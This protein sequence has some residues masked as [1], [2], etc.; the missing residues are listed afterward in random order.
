MLQRQVSK[1]SRRLLDEGSSQH[2]WVSSIVS[3]MDCDS[4]PSQCG[5]RGEC[6]LECT[7]VASKSGLEDANVLNMFRV[8]FVSVCL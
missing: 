5:I 2:I 1:R 6:G 7:R 8:M 4:S 3:G